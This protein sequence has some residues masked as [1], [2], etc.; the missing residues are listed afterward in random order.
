MAGMGC[1]EGYNRHWDVYNEGLVERGSLSLD[2]SW[3]PD[4]IKEIAEM[5]DGK[6]GRP[7]LYGNTLINAVRRLKA[8][9]EMTYRSLEG[10]LGQIFELLGIIV[11]SYQ[12][13]WRRCSASAVSASVSE[14]TRERTVA[15][16]STGI[17]VTVRG[18]WMRE[19]WKIYKGWL[20]L[21]IL[22]DVQTNEILYFIVTDERSGDAGHL[23]PL[24]DSAVAAGHRIIKVLADGAYDA[25][26]NWNGMKERKIEFIANI[27]KNARRVSR[28][29]MIRWKHVHERDLIGEEEWKKKHGYNMRWKVE[30]AISDYKRMFGEHISSKT[31][32]NMVNEIRGNIECFNLMKGATR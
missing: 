31:F 20:K 27:R 25:I 22:T 18:Q 2:L 16:D 21:H 29:C 23:L 19:K 11:P 24:V 32:G 9:S 26:Y 12:T 3:V 1:T 10:F 13:L 28:G 5:N 15:V 17:M 7:F 8:S 4:H 30:S 14:D 6:R